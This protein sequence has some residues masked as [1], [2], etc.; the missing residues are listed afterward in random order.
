MKQILIATLLAAIFALPLTAQISN[1]T[2]RVNDEQDKVTITYNLDR[3]ASFYN[4]QVRITMAG[5]VV[6]A[7][8][9][10]GDV[11]PQVLP[12]LGKKIVWDV[13]TDVTELLPG[14]L[15]IEVTT[16][17]KPK[18]NGGGF[19]APCP[20]TVTP[21]YAGLGGV[22]LSGIGLI[23]GGLSIENSSKELYDVYKA[24]LDPNDPVY[25]EMTREEHYS[26][27]NKKHKQGTGLMAAGGAVLVAG[28]VIF[29]TR[30]IKIKNYNKTCG[31][32]TGYVP[33]WKLQ[34]AVFGGGQV[35]GPGVALVYRF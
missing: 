4:I 23:V 26:E 32:K 14:E 2:T 12:G 19:S 5:E 1:V 7:K 15:K 29:V 13:H 18:P 22:G 8:G 31:G 35:P 27:A 24:T 25:A 34:P 16:D 21:T 28:G 20:M 30:L 6:N 3:G 33:N 11:G 9:L 10:S 17:T